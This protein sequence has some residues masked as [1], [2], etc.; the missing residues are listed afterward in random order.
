MGIGGGCSVRQRGLRCVWAVYGWYLYITGTQHPDACHNKIEFK[1]N[2]LFWVCFLF[3]SHKYGG[4]VHRRRRVHTKTWKMN[5]IGWR[6]W[7][8]RAFGLHEDD[9]DDAIFKWIIQRRGAHLYRRRVGPQRRCAEIMKFLCQKN[10]P[11]VC[12][13][14][15]MNSRHVCVVFVC[16]TTDAHR[17]RRN[18]KWTSF[19]CRYVS[20]EF[21]FSFLC[22]IAI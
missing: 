19:D 9:A 18:T 12:R 8:L 17:N 14:R 5:T 1:F 6:S 11:N 13:L 10:E 2:V 21:S 22:R 20:L 4:V 15:K 7:N 3:L 16:L